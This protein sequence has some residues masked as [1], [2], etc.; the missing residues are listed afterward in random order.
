M[1]R[2]KIR[3]VPLT[4]NSQK[5]GLPLHSAAWV[6]YKLPDLDPDPST[7]DEVS[8]AKSKSAQKSYIFLAGGG[9]E[10]RSGIPNAVLLVEFDFTAKSLSNHPV[11]RF[12]TVSDLPHRMAVHPRGDG[13]ICSFPK[14]CGLYV[15]NEEKSEEIKKLVLK[16]S[17]KLLTRLKDVGQQ[18]A[19]KFNNEGSALAAG[20]E[21]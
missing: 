9:G 19:L 17:D 16:K 5:Y 20:G 13:V 10:G 15:I 4:G 18:L 11:S 1:P 6:S 21:M 7:S 2:K 8:N 12:E 14:S 3:I